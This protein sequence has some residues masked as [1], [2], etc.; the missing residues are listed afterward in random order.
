MAPEHLLAF[1]EIVPLRV[2]WQQVKDLDAG[3]RVSEHP[4]D[5]CF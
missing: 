1:F 3:C 4:D 5:L 2:L